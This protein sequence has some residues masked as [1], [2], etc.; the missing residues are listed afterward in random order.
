M[1]RFFAQFFVKPGAKLD[2]LRMQVFIITKPD[3]GEKT[4]TLLNQQNLQYNTL[5]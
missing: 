5:T 1:L 4:P 2:V 3:F